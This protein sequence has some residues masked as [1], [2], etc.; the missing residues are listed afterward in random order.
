MLLWSSNELLF[1]EGH[2]T[3]RLPA[4]KDLRRGS[5]YEQEGGKTRAIGTHE[6]GTTLS[7]APSDSVG[8]RLR[9]FE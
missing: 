7:Q 4:W 3:F 5:R 1:I 2:N 6:G 8:V 9:R